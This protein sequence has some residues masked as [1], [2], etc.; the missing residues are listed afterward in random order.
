MI[1][2]LEG[3]NQWIGSVTFSPDGSRLLS[4]SMDGDIRLWDVQTGEQVLALLLDGAPY[5]HP[6]ECFVA[7]T[8][9][10][11]RIIGKASGTRIKIWDTVQ[12][13]TRN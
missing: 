5:K 12:L 10:G 8:R 6:A 1:H 9:D 13:K 7:F 3:H 11:T 2:K 4:A